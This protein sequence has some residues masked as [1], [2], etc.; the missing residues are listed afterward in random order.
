MHL[1][2]NRNRPCWYSFKNYGTF[3]SLDGWQDVLVWETDD[4]KTVP[5]GGVI[6][7]S[8]IGNMV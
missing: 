8:I 4:C 5:D 6:A 3:N 1:G 2:L 7:P